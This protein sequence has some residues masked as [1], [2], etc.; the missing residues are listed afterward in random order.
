MN[1]LLRACAL[2]LLLALVGLTGCATRNK[3]DWS[4]RVGNYTFDQAVLELGPPAKQA[5]LSDGTL[6][7]E[8]QTAVGYTRT[9]YIPYGGPYRY[10][11]YHGGYAAPLT[12]YSPGSFLRLT[13]GPDNQ[14]KAW[15]KFLM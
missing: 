7:A 14:L 10:P 3:I 2:L 12:T 11:Y 5:K 13:F 1:N 6:V 8:W 9:D 4:A 15:K